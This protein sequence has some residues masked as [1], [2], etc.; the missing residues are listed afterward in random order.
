MPFLLGPQVHS[1][2]Q[3]S[4]FCQR[5][6]VQITIH[7]KSGYAPFSMK[8]KL[9]RLL[10]CACI[11]PGAEDRNKGF[12][13]HN[14]LHSRS[15]TKRAE[16]NPARDQERSYLCLGLIKTQLRCR[17]TSLPVT[18]GCS[19][20]LFEQENKI[21]LAALSGQGERK[22]RRLDA[23]WEAPPVP[24]HVEEAR[25]A[26]EDWGHARPRPGFAGT[27]SLRC[28]KWGRSRLK[29]DPQAVAASN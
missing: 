8:T 7:I 10:H 21:K 16:S 11:Q 9:K 28:V 5:A 20:Q 4:W 25:S 24:A 22:K 17:V 1:A 6:F 19:A 26:R 27:A 23:R 14:Q 2:Y 29:I 3:G 13:E 15:T 18:R 12:K